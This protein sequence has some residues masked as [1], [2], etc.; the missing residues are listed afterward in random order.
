M[1]LDQIFG[2]SAGASAGDKVEKIIA[3]TERM[4]RIDRAID[5]IKYDDKLLVEAPEAIKTLG[6]AKDAA[7]AE[8]KTI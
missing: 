3:I 7:I 6:A 5:R 8:L 1:E 4:G 2:A